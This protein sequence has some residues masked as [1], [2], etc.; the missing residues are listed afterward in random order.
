MRQLNQGEALHALR[1]SL[2]IANKGQRRRKRGD[3]RV[4]Q[5]SCLHLV[6]H[7]VIV[8]NTVPMAEAVAQLKREGSPVTERALPHIWPTRYEHIN[9]YGRVMLP[10]R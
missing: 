1:A 5:A 8:W 2:R 10:F 4:H 3:A 6:P 9:V 7:A